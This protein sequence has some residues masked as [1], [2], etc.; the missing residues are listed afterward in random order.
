MKWIGGGGCTGQG[1]SPPLPPCYAP[2]GWPQAV[3]AHGERPLGAAV[4]AVPSHGGRPMGAAVGAAH[5]GCGQPAQQKPWPVARPRP[6]PG[7]PARGCGHANPCGG[8]PKG[9]TQASPS[10]GLKKIFFFSAIYA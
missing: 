7:P 3:L 4:G 10:Y 5:T 6:W 8:M 1:P 9:Y 2:R